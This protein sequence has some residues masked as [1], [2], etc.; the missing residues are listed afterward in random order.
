LTFFKTIDPRTEFV[1]CLRD[2]EVLKNVMKKMINNG[3]TIVVIEHNLDFI[4]DSDY[5]IDMGP[6]AGKNGGKI[7][8]EGYLNNIINSDT[9]TSIAIKK[10]LNM[11]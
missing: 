1:D 7:V 6:D 8:Y 9:Y 2:I 10:Y 11:E 4:I 5:I 3:N